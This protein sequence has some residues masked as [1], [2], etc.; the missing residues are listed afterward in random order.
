[1]TSRLDSKN[2]NIS[3]LTEIWAKKVIEAA[4][5]VH[6]ELQPGFL[7]SLY[8][9]AAMLEFRAQEIPFENQKEISV[10]Y[11]GTKIGL[12]KLDFLVADCLVVEF[13]AVEK[14]LPIHTAQAISYLKATGCDLGLLINFNVPLLKDGIVRVL[15]PK[16]Y[17]Q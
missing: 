1:M 3:P 13:K 14:L 4:M 17:R 9:E 11:R 16:F 12:H 6:R 10:A 5:N 2:I 15:H 8:E 7:E